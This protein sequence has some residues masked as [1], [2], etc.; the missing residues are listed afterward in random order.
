VIA[1]GQRLSDGTWDCTARGLVGLEHN[2]DERPRYNNFACG[3][4]TMHH[5]GVESG[6]VFG[7]WGFQ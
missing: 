2:V 4:N 1:S 3:G 5:D 7:N 6:G